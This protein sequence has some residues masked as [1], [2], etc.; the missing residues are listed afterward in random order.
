MNLAAK[1]YT[2]CYEWHYERKKT[3]TPITC[4]PITFIPIT[5][6]PKTFITNDQ[7]HV[8]VKFTI[9]KR[10]KANTMERVWNF[11]DEQQHLWSLI[12]AQVRLKAMLVEGLPSDNEVT[13]D[14]MARL[15]TNYEARLWQIV[16]IRL[17]LR[18]NISESL[19]KTSSQ[20]SRSSSKKKF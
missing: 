8:C 1:Q 14:L 17:E 3:F 5:F 2:L 19:K 7:K 11:F 9:H 4:I 13:A 6:T 18:L 20:L 10:R 16:P 15:F 12:Q